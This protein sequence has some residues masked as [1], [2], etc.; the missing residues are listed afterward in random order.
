VVVDVVDEVE[1]RGISG[2]IVVI[3][4]TGLFKV[5]HDGVWDSNRDT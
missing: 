1:V 3:V 4:I 5:G 2:V